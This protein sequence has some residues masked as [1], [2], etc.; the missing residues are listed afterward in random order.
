MRNLALFLT[1][2]ATLSLTVLISAGCASSEEGGGGSQSEISGGVYY[3]AGF[4][5]PWYYGPGYYPPGAVVSPPSG[6]VDP[7]HIEQPIAT[8]PANVAPR[9]TPLP[10]IP[11]APRPAFRR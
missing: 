11:A 4:Y 3:G 8:P 7:P 10:S 9:P 1:L 2:A 5:D 6:A